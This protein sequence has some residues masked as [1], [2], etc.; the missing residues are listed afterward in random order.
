ME[1]YDNKPMSNVAYRHI[2]STGTT[3]WNWND[4]T[5]ISETP[6]AW[7]L[8]QLTSCWQISSRN[9]CGSTNTRI[10]QSLQ[11]CTRCGTATC[12][13]QPHVQCGKRENS[14]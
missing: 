3:V 7:G 9:W 12:N 14:L 4:E 10:S 11:A 13:R 5:L 1:I 2:R 6:I 8:I